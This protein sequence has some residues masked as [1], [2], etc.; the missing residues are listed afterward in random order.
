MKFTYELINHTIQNDNTNCGVFVCLFYE[1]LLFK[2]DLEYQHSDESMK[3][4]RLNIYKLLKSKSKK[5]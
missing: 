4:A 3:D 5:I 1:N 2:K